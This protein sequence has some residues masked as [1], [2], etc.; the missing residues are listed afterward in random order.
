MGGCPPHLIEQNSRQ[1]GLCHMCLRRVSNPR[2]VSLLTSEPLQP[3]LRNT[4]PPLRKNPICLGNQSGTVI[5]VTR[6]SRINALKKSYE[7]RLSKPVFNGSKPGHSPK[8]CPQSSEQPF[9]PS[10]RHPQMEAVSRN[11]VNSSEHFVS[12]SSVP[13][14]TSLFQ[15]LG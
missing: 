11:S 2:T 15:D 8:S 9:F 7:D 12:Q 10:L 13:L 14:G 4:L 1:T 5:R 3:A 6:N